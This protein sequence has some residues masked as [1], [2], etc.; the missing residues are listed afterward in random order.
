MRK[1]LMKVASLVLA[2]VL[3]SVPAFA[4]LTGS[5]DAATGTYTVAGGATGLETSLIIVEGI[6]NA[7]PVNGDVVTG[8]VY[9]D[10]VAAAENGAAFEGVSL[11]GDVYT[12]FFSNEAQYSAASA[13]IVNA[14]VSISALDTELDLGET[15]VIAVD[16]PETATN[17]KFYE[18][19][20]E[21]AL[22]G[23]ILAGYNYTP[24]TAGTHTVTLEATVSGAVI[25]SNAI[26]FTVNEVIIAEP[27]IVTGVATILDAITNEVEDF[28][29]LP[30]G[31]KVSF[32]EGEKTIVK[33]KW[34]FESGA[35]NYYSATIPMGIVVS[36]DA[37]FAA[38]VENGTVDQETDEIS[39][40][41]EIDTVG[42]IFD[43]DGTDY[44]TNATYGDQKAQ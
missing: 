5:Y 15:A 38:V 3:F 21:I 16:A 23:S 36:G 35:N 32:G 12:A 8:A 22:E 41:I 14:S 17:V 1:N 39:G 6:H 9:I 43:V 10:Q 24:A 30:V 20:E 34:V 31:I 7:L 2:C 37:A 27:E 11:P 25:E 33:M 4:A 44:Y 28:A 40:A 13:T 26:T 19:G 18:D 42:A 29:A